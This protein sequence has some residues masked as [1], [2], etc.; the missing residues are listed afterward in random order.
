MVSLLTY[1]LQVGLHTLIVIIHSFSFLF[2][3]ISWS[4]Y[5]CV[6]LSRL[7]FVVA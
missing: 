1:R 4:F 2:L 6:V 3:F 5:S 7:V